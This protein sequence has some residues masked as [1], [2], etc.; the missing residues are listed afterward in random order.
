MLILLVMIA[1]N[2]AVYASAIPAS[3]SAESEDNMPLGLRYT[4]QHPLVIVLDWNFYPYSFNDNQGMPDGY[5][6][7]IIHEIFDNI[8]IPYEIHM[9]PFLNALESVKSKKAHLMIDIQKFDGEASLMY[10][11]RAFGEYKVA[12]A[13]PAGRKRL[14]KVYDI[15]S[16]D[17]LYMRKGD[18]AADYLSHHLPPLKCHTA[19]IEPHAALQGIIKGTVKYYVWGY[20]PLR[21][22]LL[23]T[24]HADKIRV[25]C[26]SD[27]PSGRFHFRSVDHYLLAELDHRFDRL[28]KSGHYDMVNTKWSDDSRKAA[29]GDELHDRYIFP[30]I[31]FTILLVIGIISIIFIFRLSRTSSALRKEFVAIINMVLSSTHY[32]VAVLDVKKMIIYNIKGD[33]LPP[34][35]ISLSTFESLVH[36]DDIREEYAVRNAV[37]N[38]EEDIPDA[39]FR[40]QRQADGAYVPVHVRCK[41]R[42]GKRNKPRFL[43][44]VIE[45]LKE[46]K[47]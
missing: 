37:Y 25:E 4:K 47:I 22:M 18:Y 1:S 26:V 8:H 5:E 44:M 32:Q 19:Y 3:A 14:T 23:T 39:D 6:V 11:A 38:E 21:D 2:G 33:V 34:G 7:D 10:G 41:L 30:I 40:I 29:Q 20:E 46:K 13:T 15:P 9:M 27:I 42:K 17:T 31:F 28:V 45:I 35:S 43:F 12:I 36:P 16:T 24:A